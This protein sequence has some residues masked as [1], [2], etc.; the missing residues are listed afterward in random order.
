MVRTRAD[1]D[2]SELSAND[3]TRLR[4]ALD[5]GAHMIS[6]DAPTKTDRYE[7]WVDIVGGTP[8]RCNPISATSSCRAEDL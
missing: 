6:T 7:Y 4:A 2:L 8:S 5:S 1:A 3:H